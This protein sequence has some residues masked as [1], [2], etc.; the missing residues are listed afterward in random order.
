MHTM[1]RAHQDMTHAKC[2]YIH[3]CYSRYCELRNIH[4]LKYNTRLYCMCLRV[5]VIKTTI[6]FCVCTGTALT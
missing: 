2:T 4:K 6:E 5:R 1:Q 3:T